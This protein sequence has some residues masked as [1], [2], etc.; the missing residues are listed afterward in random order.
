MADACDFVS[1]F[2]A[3]ISSSEH[4][5]ELFNREAKRL[6][7]PVEWVKDEG[8]PNI[9][10]PERGELEV[11]DSFTLTEDALCRI[12]SSVEA[13]RLRVVDEARAQMQITRSL[14][15]SDEVLSLANPA[16]LNWLQYVSDGL[17]EIS[18]DIFGRQANPDYTLLEQWMA[19]HG[20]PDSRHHFSRMRVPSLPPLESATIQRLAAEFGITDVTT[21]NPGDYGNVF[22]W[23]Q[24]KPHFNGMMP[25]DMSEEDK[26]FLSKN[27]DRDHPIRLPWT[28]VENIT[29]ADEKFLRDHGYW[30]QPDKSATIEMDRNYKEAVSW[31][32]KGNAGKWYRVTNMAFHPDYRDYFLAFAGLLKEAANLQ[33]VVEDDGKTHS[34]DVSFRRYTL[35][36][37]QAL[38]S[39]DFQ[40]LLAEDLNQTDGN[41]FLTFFPHEGYWPDGMKFPWMLE[42]GIRESRARNMPPQEAEIFKDLENRAAKTAGRHHLKYD[43]RTIDTGDVGKSSVLLWPYRTGGFMRSYFREPMGHDY[44]KREYPGI[45]LHRTVIL[46]DSIIA[47]TEAFNDIFDNL[48][49]DGDSYTFHDEDFTD[50]V[51]WHEGTHGT[52]ARPDTPT[53][54]GRTMADVYGDFW[55]DIAEPLSDA[56]SI[57]A[58]E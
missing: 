35:V 55:G 31:L 46:L 34:L 19:D 32:V 3:E 5:R 30:D 58:I 29:I 14:T 33:S 49:A 26:V 53:N 2:P 12:V 43:A 1:S 20:D 17:Q 45:D 41:L 52:G 7:Y 50:F 15:L 9:P 8:A 23:F 42:M 38:E 18:L 39:G 11:R 47:R 51:L 57:L 10:E 27:Y 56:G 44:P 4:Y 40:K 21:D 48:A 6:G 25:E 54:S 13:K 24:A 16:E 22:P 28:V 36:M 37:A